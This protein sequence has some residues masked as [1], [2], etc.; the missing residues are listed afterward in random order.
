MCVLLEGFVV[1]VRDICAVAGILNLKV[2]DK[3]ILVHFK[4]MLMTL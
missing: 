1:T 2:I 4:S 3:T